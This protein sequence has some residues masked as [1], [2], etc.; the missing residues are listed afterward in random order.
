MDARDLL[1]PLGYVAFA[2]SKPASSLAGRPRGRREEESED[3]FNPFPSLPQALEH[4]WLPPDRLP[5]VA[6]PA[7]HWWGMWAG[8]RGRRIGPIS[9][10]FCPGPF[11]TSGKA[12]RKQDL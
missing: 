2:T 12:L 1:G 5:T 11:N 10:R 3:F 9:G 7:S 4:G 8:G 6:P